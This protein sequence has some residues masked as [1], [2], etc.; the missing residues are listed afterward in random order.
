MAGIQTE[1]AL[2]GVTR[3]VLNA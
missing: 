1:L 2:P 3:S